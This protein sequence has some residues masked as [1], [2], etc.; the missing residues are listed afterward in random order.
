MTT[1]ATRLDRETA[2]KLLNELRARQGDGPETISAV[3]VEPALGAGSTRTGIDADDALAPWDVLVVPHAPDSET[4]WVG[5]PSGVR[6]VLDRYGLRP[7]VS[8]NYGARAPV[9]YRVAQALLPRAHEMG[10]VVHDDREA[11]VIAD[12]GLQR[13]S[14]RAERSVRDVAGVRG[15][16][17]VAEQDP[18]CPNGTRGCP[19]P[20]APTGVLPCAECFADGAGG[21]LDG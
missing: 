12:G 3:I 9:T 19:G 16:A 5:L 8:P 13:H 21:G 11:E 20:D 6:D 7:E 17:G 18:T 4:T 1:T 14:R 2:T 15:L 10:R